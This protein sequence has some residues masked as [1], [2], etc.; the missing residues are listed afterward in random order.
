MN[1]NVRFLVGSLVIVAAIAWLM[2]SGIRETSAYYMTLAEF[3]PRRETLVGTDVRIAGRVAPGSIRWDPKTLR[4]DFAVGEP[5]VAAG[6]TVPV[7]FTGVKPDMFTEGRDVIIEGHYAAG[8]LR[9]DKVLTSC[10]SKYEA[11]VQDADA[12]PAKTEG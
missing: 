11:R 9:A 6:E 12:R 1:R 5:G 2:Y 7:A 3:A 8:T 4:L 10:P